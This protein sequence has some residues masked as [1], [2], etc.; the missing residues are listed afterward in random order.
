MRNGAEWFAAIGTEKSKG[1]KVFALAG[2]VNNTGLI[3]V[4]MGI[5]LR[6][7]IYEIGGGIPDGKQFKAVQTG[8]PS[9]GC[10]PARAPRYAGRLRIARAARLHHGLGRHDRHG[11]DLLHGGRRQVLH[12]VLHERILRQVHPL[13]R[14][15]APDARPAREDHRRPTPPPPTWRCSKS[16]ATWSCNTSLCGLGQ[17]APNPVLTTLRYFREEYDAHIAGASAPPACSAAQITR[18]TPV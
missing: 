17:S 6:E 8:G 10:I 15:H 14:R 4:P 16:S 13:P 1:T 5:T 3:E 9:G 12:G 18:R 7:I 2:R 11:R